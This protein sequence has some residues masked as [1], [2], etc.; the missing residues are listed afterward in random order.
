MLPMALLLV[1]YT[2]DEDATWVEYARNV[3]NYTFDF[4]GA[5]EVKFYPRINAWVRLLVA[6]CETKLFSKDHVILHTPSPL[7]PSLLSFPATVILIYATD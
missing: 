1:P 2:G 7:P 4:K 3:V 6:K 5:N